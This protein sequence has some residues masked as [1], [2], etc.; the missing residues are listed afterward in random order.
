SDLHYET[1]KDGKQP[2]DLKGATINDALVESLWKEDLQWHP[3]IVLVAGDLVNQNKPQNY[4]LYIDLVKKLVRQF[5]HL[6]HSFFSTPG[7]H[8]VNRAN[9]VATFKYLY[10]NKVKKEDKGISSLNLDPVAKNIFQI[11]KMGLENGTLK[12]DLVFLEQEYF[13]IYLEQNKK[14]VDEDILAK[15]EPV[16]PVDGL[17][18]VYQISRFGI[19]IV[20]INSSFFCSLTPDDRNNLFLI[21]ELIDKTVENLKNVNG[22]IVSFMHHPFYF[23]HDSEHIAPAPTDAGHANDYNNF[24]KVVKNSDLI[25]SG[26]VHG[27]LQDPTSQQ[28]SAFLITNGT[29]YT[30]DKFHDK[31]Y[32]FTYALIKINK[33]L[34]KFALRK[35]RHWSS[36]NEESPKKAT[37]FHFSALAGHEP[38]YNFFSRYNMGETRVET[39]KLRTLN[40]FYE[41]TTLSHRDLHFFLYQIR[42]YRKD[43]V[44]NESVTCTLKKDTLW[45]G[46]SY[47]LS[48]EQHGNAIINICNNENYLQQIREY[49]FSSSFS[50]PRDTVLYFSI[51]AGF[52][53]GDKKKE[54][55]ME[56]IEQYRNFQT[57]VMMSKTN[58][59]SINL[60]YHFSNPIIL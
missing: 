34:N 22:P 11:K 10:N 59:V 35:A 60:L 48:F 30:M 55:E 39:E 58:S 54:P 16:Y 47:L 6:K 45:D 12:E 52:L 9:R 3:D 13:D 25:L 17:K 8:D 18:T 29:S 42:L 43:L 28:Q 21:N 26:H 14:L 44:D 56:K 24:N 49:L 27:D 37:G 4:P 46:N 32:P 15:V 19:N 2:E 53:F 5:P 7:N 51:Y 33:Q 57:I 23:L 20:S 41:K 50:V 36:D 40:Y 1:A 31:S 38:Y